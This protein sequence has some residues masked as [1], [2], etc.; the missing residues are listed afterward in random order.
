M[1]LSGAGDVDQALTLVGEFLAVLPPGL[2]KRVEWRRY[3]ALWVGVASRYDFIFFKLFAAADSSGPRSVHYQDL[4]ALRPS[5]S[6]LDEAATWV[7]TQDAAAEFAAILDRVVV[8]LRQD[9]AIG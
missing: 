3:A 4:L 1:E 8:H 9:L 7:R 5:S 2:Q 6:E